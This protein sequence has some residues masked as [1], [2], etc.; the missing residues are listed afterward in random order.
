MLAALLE[1][2]VA[3]LGASL[4]LGAAMRRDPSLV[5]AEVQRRARR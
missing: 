1:L 3:A 4:A 5:L 2:A